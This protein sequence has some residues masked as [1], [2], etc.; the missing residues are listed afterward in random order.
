VGPKSRLARDQPWVGNTVMTRLRPTL[1]WEMR[2]RNAFLTRPRVSR[3]TLR[4]LPASTNHFDPRMCA[5][6]T[7]CPVEGAKVNKGQHDHGLIYFYHP[8]RWPGREN[9]VQFPHSNLC[10]NHPERDYMQR[11]I[12]ASKE[13]FVSSELGLSQLPQHVH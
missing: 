4:G 1:G 8:Q 12:S 3:S 10:F 2:A 11:L 7:T 6:T 5:R 9:R 13:I